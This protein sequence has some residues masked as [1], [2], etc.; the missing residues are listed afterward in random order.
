M[1]WQPRR[2]PLR[3]LAL[4]K[5]GRVDLWLTD[6]SGFPLP[7]LA[8]VSGRRELLKQ[9][10]ISQRFLTRLLLGAYLGVPGKAI[11]LASDGDGKPRLMQAPVRAD[12]R[13]SISH[14]GPWLA[15]AVAVGIELGVDIEA[16]R[17][18]PRAADLARRYFSAAESDYLAKCP[19]AQQSD[20]FL[21]CW[22]VREAL[23]KANGCGLARAL[24]GIELVAETRQ[25]RR[26]PAHWPSI[27]CVLAPSWPH[28]LIGH[29]AAPVESLDLSGRLL[30]TG[31]SISAAPDK[32]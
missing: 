12:L 30:L 25:I 18:L 11:E 21:A 24:A 6:L 4:P 2:L 19:P 8:R 31:A 23:V 17:A 16:V 26:L 20:E 32:R 7:S 9:R 22:T 5:P 3:P 10:R 29:L 13:F 14:S 15:I 1:D 28:G 27:W